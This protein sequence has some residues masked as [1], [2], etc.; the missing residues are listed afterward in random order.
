MV[1]WYKNKEISEAHG[2]RGRDRG[3]RRKEWNL[4]GSSSSSVVCDVCKKRSGD[5]MYTTRRSRVMKRER[6]WATGTSK[7]VRSGSEIGTRTGHGQ[8]TLRHCRADSLATLTRVRSK[9][10]VGAF[11]AATCDEGTRRSVC[12]GLKSAALTWEKWVG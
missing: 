11:R 7:L 6:R 8:P 9:T 10:N 1:V 2:T 3:K 12:G 4:T 5:L